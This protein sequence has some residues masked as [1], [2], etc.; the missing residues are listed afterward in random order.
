[1]LGLGKVHSWTTA[2][3]FSIPIYNLLERLSTDML[4][5]HRLGSSAVWLPTG[6]TRFNME[7]IYQLTVKSS[8]ISFLDKKITGSNLLGF[9]SEQ[10]L[11]IFLLE[12]IEDFIVCI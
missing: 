4:D 11:Q 5:Y 9:R 12:W 3:N 2:F 7:D 6:L 1:M 10:V 8:S